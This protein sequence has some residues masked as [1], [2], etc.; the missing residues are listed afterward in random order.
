MIDS[1][2]LERGRLAECERRRIEEAHLLHHGALDRR[3]RDGVALHVDH[4]DLSADTRGNI[5]QI[6]GDI[7]G[8]DVSNDVEAKRDRRPIEA[9][10]QDAFADLRC[11]RRARWR[12][13]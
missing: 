4:D 6:R 9:D 11:W 8:I 13:T 12:W 5:S 10:Q 1:E 2:R 3:R 7:E